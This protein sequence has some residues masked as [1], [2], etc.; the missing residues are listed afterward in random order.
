[1]VANESLEGK[2]EKVV[3]SPFV[4]KRSTMELIKEATSFSNLNQFFN[5][6]SNNPSYKRLIFLHRFDLFGIDNEIN[7]PF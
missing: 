1:M 6:L 3:R 4:S 7:I 5:Q 2:I